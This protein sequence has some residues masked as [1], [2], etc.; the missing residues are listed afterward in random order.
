MNCYIDESGDTGFSKKS[1]KNFILTGFVISESDSEKLSKDI[2]KYFRKI[3]KIYKNRPHFFHAYKETDKTRSDLLKIINKHEYKVLY[4]VIK[5]KDKK[6]DYA[7]EINKFISRL[8]KEVI[9][10]CISKYDTR[11]SVE[12]KIIASNKSRN[13]SFEL[14][15]TNNL[16]QVADLFSW[17]IFNKYEL[18]KEEFY[19]SIVTPERQ[20]P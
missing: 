10:I 7:E 12:V 9:N 4:S 16:L 3:I 2:K 19:K 6:V 1:T 18:G 15:R 20:N 13:I 8:D 5:K 11:K 14:S 17:I